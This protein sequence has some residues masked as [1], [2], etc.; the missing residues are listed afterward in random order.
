MRIHE[1]IKIEKRHKILAFHNSIY[2]YA[3]RLFYNR[4]TLVIRFVIKASKKLI[5]EFHLEL[6]F[7]FI[8]NLSKNLSFCC[9]TY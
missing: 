3:I 2:R 5:N 7:L 1:S 4:F 9:Y 8:N 6:K